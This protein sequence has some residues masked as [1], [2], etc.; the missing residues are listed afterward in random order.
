MNRL[1]TS[2]REVLMVCPRDRFISANQR[3]G[4]TDLM[5]THSRTYQRFPIR[6]IKNEEERER[7]RRRGEDQNIDSNKDPIELKSEETF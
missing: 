7:E 2:T 1:I 3:S 5:A 6:L 4:T